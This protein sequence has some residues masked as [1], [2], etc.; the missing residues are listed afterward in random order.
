MSHR[1]HHTSKASVAAPVRRPVAA[2]T[3]L[4]ALFTLLLL[5]LGNPASAADKSADGKAADGK[6][7]DNKPADN[8]VSRGQY[9]SR[10]GGCM[11]CHTAE[12]KDGGKEGVP[13]AGGRA[14]KTPFGTFYGP[15]LTPHTEAGLGRW[16]E[17]DFI[18]AMRLGLRP[19]GAH[20]FPA[21]PYPS[22]TK[23]S[24]ADLKDLWAY[25]RSLPPDA[26]ANRA[27]EL[28]F[29]F[30]F[31]FLLT[32]WKWLYFTPGP[33]SPDAAQS[34]PQAQLARGAYVTQA[35]SHCGE[36]HSGRNVL[37]GIRKDRILAGAAKGPEGKSVPNLT[38]TG[39]KKWDDNDLRE[40]LLSGMTPDGDVTAEAMAEVVRNTTSQLTAQ[41]LAALMAYLRSLPALPSEK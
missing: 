29:P 32:G 37:G 1:P 23:L 19:D 12:A 3:L 17:Q 25:L 40:F 26:T 14:L 18:R 39:L 34:A 6:A 11:A 8:A 13:Y 31:R 36:C 22:F 16:G 28:R 38:P 30:G 33:M 7:V 20:Y 5:P 41:D 2:T 15:N 21:F 4:L 35:L 10:A 27:H 24:D 9:L